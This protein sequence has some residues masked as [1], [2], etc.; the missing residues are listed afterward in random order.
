VLY[1]GTE[2][3]AYVTVDMGKTWTR[4]NANLPTVPVH[5]FAQHPL[6]GDL[7]VGTHG[8]SIWVLDAPF[9]SQVNA[10]VLAADAH[11]FEPADVVVWRR[12]LGRSID[13][14]RA[15]RGTNPATGAVLRYSLGKRASEVKL[16][17]RN[18]T[19]DQVQTFEAPREKGLHQ[20][21]WNLTFRPPTPPPGEG[22]A[23]GG[24]PGSGQRRGRGGF[25]GG[26]RAGTGD[27]VVTLTVDGRSVSKELTILADPN[28]ADGR[29]IALEDAFAELE[30]QLEAEGEDSEGRD[31]EVQHDR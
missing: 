18:A 2:F 25:G 5:D 19:G 8:R 7:V 23:Q 9:T 20:I 13:R 4:M 15:F 27:Y 1:L 10:E 17:V 21:D 28:E 6:T 26:R 3:G 31:S 14:T 11:L 30:A 22:A 16:E 29:Y 24:G 12:G